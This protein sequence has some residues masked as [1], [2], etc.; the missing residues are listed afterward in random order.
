[1]LYLNQ[2]INIRTL[3]LY[4]YIPYESIPKVLFNIDNNIRNESLTHQNLYQ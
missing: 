2:Y 1:M 4:D 3:L